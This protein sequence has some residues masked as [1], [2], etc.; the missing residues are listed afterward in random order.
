MTHETRAVV[1]RF[2][3]RWTPDGNADAQAF[4]VDLEDLIT[5]VLRDALEVVT[6]PDA[7]IP[8]AHGSTPP[9]STPGSGG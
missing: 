2:M 5:H 3:M 6:K 9:V 7:P 1:S 8:E 4:R